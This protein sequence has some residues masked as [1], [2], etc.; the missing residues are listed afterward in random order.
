MCFTGA[1]CIIFADRRLIYQSHGRENGS[2]LTAPNISPRVCVTAS[3]LPGPLAPLPVPERGKMC[4]NVPTEG[5]TEATVD[6]FGLVIVTE[7]QSGRIFDFFE[8]YKTTN[9]DIIRLSFHGSY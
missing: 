2:C 5:I 6:H 8:D 9:G 7:R 3:I 4:D 1:E